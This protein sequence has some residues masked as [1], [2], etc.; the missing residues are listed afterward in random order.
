MLRGLLSRAVEGEARTAARDQE[1]KV[2][3]PVST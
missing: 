2:G 3:E 1:R